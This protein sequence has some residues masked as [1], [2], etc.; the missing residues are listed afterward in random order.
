MARLGR[1]RDAVGRPDRPQD[2][3]AGPHQRDPPVVT[4][5]TPASDPGHLAERTQLIEQARLVAG[6]PRRQHVPLEDRGRDRQP[7]QLVDDLGQALE[8]GRRA[9]GRAGHADRGH[10]LPHRQEPGQRRGVDRLDLAPE[11]R[12]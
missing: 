6:D 8:R 7:G 9:E 5:E 3:A 1:W 2:L 12:Q 4:P 10:T 11:A